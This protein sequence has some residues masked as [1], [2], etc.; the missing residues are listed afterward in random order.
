MYII[1]TNITCAKWIFT[2]TS[3]R[4]AGEM[5]AKMKLIV[6]LV[7]NTLLVKNWKLDWDD[8]EKLEIQKGKFSQDEEFTRT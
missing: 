6:L 1:K 4:N 8:T 7:H 5:M 3:L 2:R